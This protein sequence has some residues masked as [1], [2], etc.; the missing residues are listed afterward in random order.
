MDQIPDNQNPDVNVDDMDTPTANHSK[1][2]WDV[3]AWLSLG[4]GLCL[5]AGAALLAFWPMRLVDQMP[6]V[7]QTTPSARPAEAATPP[8][9]SNPSTPLPVPTVPHASTPTV[10]A[11]TPTPALQSTPT[12]QPALNAAT[13]FAGMVLPV[14]GTVGQGYAL[15]VLLYNSTL[16]QWQVHRGV[17]IQAPAGTPVKAALEGQVASVTNDPLLGVMVVVNHGEHGQTI[18]A[19]LTENPPVAQGDKVKAGDTIGSVGTTAISESDDGPHLHFEV[20]LDG[21]SINPADFLPEA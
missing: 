21:V 9:L 11:P 13:V 20:L 14:N 6:P 12:A 3:T 1:R 15:E 7:A 5:V 17:D 10:A 2:L 18:Y 16:R 8:A 4:L 19:G